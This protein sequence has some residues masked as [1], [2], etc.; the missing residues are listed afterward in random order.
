MCDKNSSFSFHTTFKKNYYA[1]FQ[2]E[3]CEGKTGL[4]ARNTLFSEGKTKNGMDN[5][6]IRTIPWHAS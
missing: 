4:K 5:L 3:D 6:L 1:E 2:S